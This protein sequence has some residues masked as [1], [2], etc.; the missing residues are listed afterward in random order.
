MGG[1]YICA[2]KKLLPSEGR[3]ADTAVYASERATGKLYPVIFSLLFLFRFAKILNHRKRVIAPLAK[4]HRTKFYK[5]IF[6]N[7]SA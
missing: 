2:I 3:E 5:R 1:K 4:R 6:K 7:R